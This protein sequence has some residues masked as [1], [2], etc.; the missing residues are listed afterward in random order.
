MP[1]FRPAGSVGSAV[2]TLSFAASVVEVQLNAARIRLPRTSGSRRRQP[3]R[4]T[5]ESFNGAISRRAL[6]LLEETR[7]WAVQQGPG[8][9]STPL[10]G[11]ENTAVN[12]LFFKQQTEAF[13]RGQ[14]RRF[15]SPRPPAPP[16]W[17]I[18]HPCPV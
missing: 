3:P 9:L 18:F 6:H 12:I 7:R 1:P 17:P 10:D 5:L 4:P 8:A 13:A 16:L 14:S 11:G 15:T 2:Q